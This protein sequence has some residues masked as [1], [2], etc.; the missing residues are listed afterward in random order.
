ML[1]TM[2][3]NL[4]ASG[5][6][7]S[8]AA[9]LPGETN[10][11]SASVFCA[12]NPPAISAGAASYAL[13]GS[14]D[15]THG[16]GLYYGA[17]TGATGTTQQ[18]GAFLY[19]T[20]TSMFKFAVAPASTMAPF[21]SRKHL[22]TLVYDA[23]TT[24]G[25]QLYVDG[26]FRTVTAM[27]AAAGFAVSSTAAILGGAIAGTTGSGALPAGCGILGAAYWSAVLSAA[28]VAAYA[29]AA[30][31]AGDMVTSVNSGRA[32]AD[33][34]TAPAI[35]VPTYC[36]SAKQSNNG[37]GAATAS[38]MAAASAT[39]TDLITGLVLTATGSPKVV[40]SPF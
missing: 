27:G 2:I 40:S 11:F 23:T 6:Y 3:T 24:T 5:S 28:E 36:W 30:F 13:F 31:L 26:T 19:D 14:G 32:V 7:A 35:V 18:F 38:S 25:L 20:N 33:I 39:W 21:S 17:G 8:A 1:G 4:G 10:G 15:A 34:G 37:S 12:I 22:V 9:A 29:N 16:W